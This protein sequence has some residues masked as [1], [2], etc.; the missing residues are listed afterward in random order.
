MNPIPEV[1]EESKH[2]DPA[3]SLVGPLSPT[4]EESWTSRSVL[5][6]D[7]RE[8]MWQRW[9]REIADV[10]DERELDSTATLPHHARSEIERVGARPVLE[11]LG[12][13]HVARR[14]IAPVF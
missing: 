4:P 1:V 11:E 14:R 13:L 5:S 8:V 6:L 2:A 9:K 12:L 7:E 3:R 10:L